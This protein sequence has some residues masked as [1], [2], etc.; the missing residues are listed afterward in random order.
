MLPV[1]GSGRKRGPPL[2]VINILYALRA[3]GQQCVVPTKHPLTAALI[4]FTTLL[5]R[6]CACVTFALRAPSWSLAIGS[7]L[8]L[9]QDACVPAL[10]ADRGNPKPPSVRSFHF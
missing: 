10:G 1:L 4:L 6:F 9:Q 5:D 8:L 7:I 3:T 2:T